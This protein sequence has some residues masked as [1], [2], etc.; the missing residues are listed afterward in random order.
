MD[1]TEARRALSYW[2]RMLRRYEAAAIAVGIEHGVGSPDHRMATLQAA[3]VY[4][5][6]ITALADL[7][8]CQ[9]SAEPAA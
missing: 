3:N 4:E 5:C 7:R 9:I 6:Y 1:I 8:I 2:R